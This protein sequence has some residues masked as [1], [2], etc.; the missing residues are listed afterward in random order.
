MT[1]V[2]I[3]LKDGMMKTI[4]LEAAKEVT[5]ITWNSNIRQISIIG[6]RGDFLLFVKNGDK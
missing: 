3:E 5:N 1:K 4:D 6:P 2:Q